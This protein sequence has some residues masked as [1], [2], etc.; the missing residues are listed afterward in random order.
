MKPGRLGSLLGLQQVEIAT[1]WTTSTRLTDFTATRDSEVT[2]IKAGLDLKHYEKMDIEGN[3]E[4]LHMPETKA[5]RESLYAGTDTVRG[6]ATAGGNSTPK[7]HD[8]SYWEMTHQLG[9]LDTIKSRKEKM[10]RGELVDATGN[11]EPP[12]KAARKGDGK[13]SGKKAS[14]SS[15]SVVLRGDQGQVGGWGQQSQWQGGWK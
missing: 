3:S 11:R 10:Q 14:S 5:Y 7:V 6:T 15:G 2:L 13:D 4:G 8:P 1:W 9:N 12:S